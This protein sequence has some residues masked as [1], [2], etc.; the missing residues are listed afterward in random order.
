MPHHDSGPAML[1][2][3]L[4]VQCE[5][6]SVVTLCV[7]LLVT[8]CPP[9]TQL[10]LEL[11]KADA[12]ADLHRIQDNLEKIHSCSAELGSVHRENGERTLESSCTTFS[13]LVLRLMSV[14]SEK[15]FFLKEVF[16]ATYGRAYDQNL[17][18]LLS[19]FL[20]RL[21]QLLPTPTLAQTVAWLPDSP[22]AAEE[23]SQSLLDPS[24]LETLLLH[25]RGLGTL[26]RGSP[27]AEEVNPIM[28]AAAR[29]EEDQDSGDVCGREEEFRDSCTAH[30]H[31]W[32]P[33]EPPGGKR[34]TPRQPTL[35][36]SR[37]QAVDGAVRKGRRK[38]SDDGV[39]QAATPAQTRRRRRKGVE[40]EERAVEEE[41][42]EGAAAA[43]APRG[44]DR[45]F[46]S[47]RPG[48]PR[49]AEAETRCP[50]CDKTFQLPNQLKTHLRLHALPYRCL[51]CEKGFG[52]KSGYYQHQRLHKKGRAFPC[53]HCPLSFLCRYS[54][55]QHQRTHADGPAH[56]C[57]ECGKRFSEVSMVRHARMH[58]GRKDYLCPACGKTFLSSG[59]L[60]LHTR[61]HTRD[62]PYTCTH[63]GKGFTT[64]SHL[65]VH[66]RSHT[67]ERPYAC[68]ACPKRFLTVSC[69]KRHMLSHDGIKPFSCPTCPKAFSQNG[70]LKKHMGT[71]QLAATAPSWQDGA[72]EEHM[73]TH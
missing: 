12:P 56:L 36:L 68:A 16:P 51:P 66:G 50:R 14:P 28:A 63:C 18:R 73:G 25:H 31:G 45:R 62:T 65:T 57:P 64:K 60:L 21:E 55:R 53:S 52:S 42:T 37:G 20:S 40:E 70:N 23:L 4:A 30:S 47:T 35:K 67:G 3:V 24:S 43:A 38:E 8:L 10:I 29:P 2:N 46:L 6:R 5:T 22:S 9:L 49:Y 41:G 33:T 32:L 72:P 54:L 71:H 17:R 27:C 13:Q 19:E 59:E 48:H 11:C 39:E 7:S 58:A 1:L 15:E 26:S 61:T 34:S 44:E 69:L